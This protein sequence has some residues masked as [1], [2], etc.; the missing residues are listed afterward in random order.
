MY[1]DKLTRNLF[2][3]IVSFA[4]GLAVVFV[5]GAMAAEAPVFEGLSSGERARVQELIAG[6]EK[7]GDVVM[8]T[9]T[10]G[11]DVAQPLFEDFQSFYGLKNVQL[12]HT[13][14]RSGSVISTLKQDISAGR[15]TFDIIQVGSP[16]FM[17]ELFHRNAL[18]KYESPNYQNFV[19]EVTGLKPGAVAV[20]GYFI[21][22]QVL[23]FGIV[24]NTKFVKKD[25]KTWEDVLDPKYKGKIIVA[26]ILKSATIVN[27]YGGLRTVLPK[28]YFE[29]LAKQDPIFVLSHREIVRKIVAGEKWIGVMNSTNLA[30][31]AAK[32]GAPLKAILPPG[33]TVALGYPLAILAKAPHPDAAKL[34][35]DYLHSSRGY[36]RYLNAKGFTSGLKNA[37]VSPLIRSFSPPVEALEII[38][39]DWDKIGPKQ[40]KDWRAE[41]KKIFYKE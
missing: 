17:L 27:I 12:R 29:K 19:P 5:S 14:K 36:M 18:M 28:S 39:M 13:M 21:S 35:I 9:N 34:W 15:N 26:D 2:R 25:I 41:Y 32:D 1:S 10:M 11:P 3:R 30:Y 24:S 16:A 4:L 38:P 33:G 8:L 23:T 20:P 22:G 7:E 37:E 31:K 40:V 6:A